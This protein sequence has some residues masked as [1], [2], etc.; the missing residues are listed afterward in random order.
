MTLKSLKTLLAA[1][2]LAISGPTFL[3][4]CSNGDSYEDTATSTDAEDTDTDTDSD[5]DE[6]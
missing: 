6:D 3:T 2:A 5:S 4:A 1:L